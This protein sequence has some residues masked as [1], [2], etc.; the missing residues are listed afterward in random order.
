MLLAFLV[1]F[2]HVGS[3]DFEVISLANISFENQ[4]LL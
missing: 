1:I 3:S 4:K 2:Y